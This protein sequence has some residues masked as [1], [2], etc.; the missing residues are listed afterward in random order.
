MAKGFCLAVN[1]IK[2]QEDESEGACER[3]NCWHC[4]FPCRAYESSNGL[5][6][7]QPQFHRLPVRVTTTYW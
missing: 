5:A 2:Y 1:L 3:Q 4:M 6:A 7:W